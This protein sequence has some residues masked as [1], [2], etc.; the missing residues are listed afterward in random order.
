MSEVLA[1]ADVT[2]SLSALGSDGSVD[3][4]DPATPD[5][6]NV[7]TLSKPTWYYARP[8]SGTVVHRGV[9]FDRGIAQVEDGSLAVFRRAG[10]AIDGLVDAYAVTALASRGWNGPPPGQ[11]SLGGWWG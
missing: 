2:W 8:A 1:L 11:W 5:G 10:Y 9:T 4:E 6:Y 3:F 7:R